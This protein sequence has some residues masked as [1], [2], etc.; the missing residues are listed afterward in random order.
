MLHSIVKTVLAILGQITK[1]IY[2]FG[3]SHLKTQGFFDG[4]AW[5]RDLHEVW[6]L[7]QCIQIIKPKGKNKDLTKPDPKQF[8]HLVVSELLWEYD[9]LVVLLCQLECHL[10]FFQGVLWNF[11]TPL[12]LLDLSLL[13]P[14]QFLVGSH[15]RGSG[16]GGGP[17]V[18][19]GGGN[20]LGAR[21]KSH[22]Q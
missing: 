16:N 11:Q 5:T 14:D 21:R 10:L 15:G 7:L 6:R 20:C 2:S 17:G 8:F 19:D 12:Q 22:L 9:L 13:T 18:G 1:I 3:F 4:I